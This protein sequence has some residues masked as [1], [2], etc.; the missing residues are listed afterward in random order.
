MSDFRILVINPGSTS[1]KL[2]YFVGNVEAERGRIEHPMDELG[3]FPDIPSQVGYR[4]GLVEE[5]I[6]ADGIISKGLDAIAAR[7]GLM[8]PVKKRHIPH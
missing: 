7:G 8:K 1:T 2:S 3:R 5:F 6:G 4:L